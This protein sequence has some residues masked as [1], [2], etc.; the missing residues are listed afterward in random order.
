MSHNLY[1]LFRAHFSADRSRPMLHDAQNRALTYAEVESSVSRMIGAFTAAGVRP[2]DRIAV[3][4]EKS[5]ELLVLY[6]ATLAGGF[7]FQPINPAYQEGELRDLLTDAEPALVVCEP[8]RAERIAALCPARV[9][10]LGI[11]GA[12]TLLEAAAAAMP[13]KAICDRA[14]DDPAALLY[15]SGT[16]GK[17]KGAILT[18]G[19]LASNGEALVQSWGFS[20]SDRLL[21]AL[22][23]FH[24][25][26]LFV[27]VSCALL[28]GAR[29]RFLPRFDIATVLRFLPEA[30]VFMGVPTYYTRLLE[31]PGFGSDLCGSI[32]LFVSGS[33]PLLAETFNRF[34]AV[35]GHAILERYGMTETLMN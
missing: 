13:V 8:P 12:G 6:F 20:S 26:G 33:A 5:P 14:A 27:A 25:H 9:L 22:P 17:P 23:L 24:A 19:N 15:S 16:T 2:G 31:E 35:T 3:Q 4:V 29:M 30:T 7:F 32:R 10:T 28:S 1:Q 18:H 11:D 34:R 21:H